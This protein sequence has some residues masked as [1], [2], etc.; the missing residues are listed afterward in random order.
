MM[1]QTIEFTLNGETM[2]YSV[3]V[4]QS[5]LELLRDEL[6]LTGTKEGCGVGECGACTVIV[7]GETVDSCIY[8]AVWADG[9]T[10]TTVEGLAAEDGS[11]SDVQTAYVQDGAV[12]CGFCIPGMVL[13]STQ[14]LEDNPTPTRPEIKRALSGNM[15]RCTGYQKIVDAVADV[16]EKRQENADIAPVKFTRHA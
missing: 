16:A 10:L 13:S 15:C 12:Q 5:L 14:F 4:R 3:D 7:D 2:H 11:L 8:L 1:N 6:A 9:K